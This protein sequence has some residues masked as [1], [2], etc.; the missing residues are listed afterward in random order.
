MWGM[1][2]NMGKRLEGK[3]ALVLGVAPGNIGAAIARRYGE[4]GARV[5]IA[6]LGF[7]SRAGLAV[8]SHNNATLA[9]ALFDDIRLDR[10]NQ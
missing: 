7:D 1:G 8:T 9:T 6:G 3:R 5:T 4:H 2:P 10:P